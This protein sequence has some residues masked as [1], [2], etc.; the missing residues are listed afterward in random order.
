MM[1][2]PI[3]L[4]KEALLERLEEV[5]PLVV[6]RDKKVS[7]EHALAEHAALVD[8]R[9]KLWEQLKK[10]YKEIIAESPKH[11]SPGEVVL[12]RPECP[13]PLMRAW[14]NYHSAVTLSQQKTYKIDASSQRQLYSILTID[15]PHVEDFC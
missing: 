3:S 15:T 8:Y 2:T 7:A 13:I 10:S 5:K 1:T 11:Y 14:E 9:A 6:R 4:T 12:V